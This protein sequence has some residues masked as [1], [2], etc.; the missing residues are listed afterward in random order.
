MKQ[1]MINILKNGYT[2][3]KK[4]NLNDISKK[5]YIFKFI[6]NEELKPNNNTFWNI[7]NEENRIKLINDIYRINKFRIK[8]FSY[9]CI[10]NNF[11]NGNKYGIEVK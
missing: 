3:T 6:L 9:F 4:Y 2:K 10:I 7:E 11:V 1:I 8:D 5:L